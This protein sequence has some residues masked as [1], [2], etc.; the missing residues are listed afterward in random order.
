MSAVLARHADRATRCAALT[1][2]L[3]C[4]HRSSAV[5]A[6]RPLARSQLCVCAKVP[7]LVARVRK[8]LAEGYA[9]IIGLQSTGEAALERAIAEDGDLRAPISLCAAMLT[10]F[11]QKCVPHRLQP[12]LPVRK[13]SSKPCCSLPSARALAAQ[14]SDEHRSQSEAAK[15][16]CQSGGAPCFLCRRPRQRPCRLRFRTIQCGHAQS[17][18]AGPF[19]PPRYRRAHTLAVE[20]AAAWMQHCRLLALRRTACSRPIRAGADHVFGERASMMH[21]LCPF[22]IG[23]G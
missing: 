9:P 21:R 4:A 17:C 22:G 5:C 7:A 15:G 6:V 13:K 18:G 8:A 1:N 3:P 23:S 19:Q 12:L 16:A 2:Y 10:Q 11:I 14:F 20:R